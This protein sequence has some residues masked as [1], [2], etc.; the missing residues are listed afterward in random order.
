MKRRLPLAGHAIPLRRIAC[1]AQAA[2][3]YEKDEPGKA[4]VCSR[5]QSALPEILRA[6]AA[7][8]QLSC[9]PARSIRQAL[10]RR[11]FSACA[12]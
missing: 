4:V 12:A 3:M 6:S 11:Q 5:P 1:E 10:T 9:G 7:R 8:G 2:Q